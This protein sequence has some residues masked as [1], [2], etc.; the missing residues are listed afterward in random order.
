MNSI[1]F[2]NI[3]KTLNYHN[4]GILSNFKIRHDFNEKDKIFGYKT[5]YWIYYI[6]LNHNDF[7]NEY[8]LYGKFMIHTKDPEDDKFIKFYKDCINT[9]LCPMI[10]YTNSNLGKSS[11]TICIY[12]DNNSK[13][14]L[15][16][17]E[18]LL[19]QNVIKYN[20]LPFRGNWEINDCINDENGNKYN[21]KRKMMLSDFRGI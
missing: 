5:K 18:F 15:L 13:H 21:I 6:N 16:L 17:A 14:I 4:C 7:L 9:G 12:T 1:K 20:D 19:K 8:C 11:K 3:F 2:N 10:K